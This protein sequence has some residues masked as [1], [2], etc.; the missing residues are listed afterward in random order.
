MTSEGLSFPPEREIHKNTCHYNINI[1]DGK[2]QA[3]RPISYKN[4]TSFGGDRFHFNRNVFLK[5]PMRRLDRRYR[6]K[7]KIFFT[8][9]RGLSNNQE[10]IDL[11]GRQFSKAGTDV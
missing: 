5:N 7:G 10:G 1:F 4:M 6:I 9:T 11:G 2:V 8:E 3:Q